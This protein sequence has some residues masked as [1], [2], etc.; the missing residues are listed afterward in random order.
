[1]EP[2]FNTLIVIGAILLV[3]IILTPA[4]VMFFKWLDRKQEKR[5]SAWETQYEKIQNAIAIHQPY[6]EVC[7]MMTELKNIRWSNPEKERVLLDEFAREY[8]AERKQAKAERE[9]YIKDILRQHIEPGM[10]KETARKYYEKVKPL[11]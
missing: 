9:K 1:M 2:L 4:I 5:E 11:L 6:K 8:Q 10:S 7:D 3:S